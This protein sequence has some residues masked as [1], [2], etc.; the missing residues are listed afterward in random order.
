MCCFP[1]SKPPKPQAEA[2]PKAPAAAASKHWQQRRADLGGADKS[3]STVA[4]D[5]FTTVA[6]FL[7]SAAM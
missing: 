6:H 4:P 5:A 2:A 1:L 3:Q 7:V